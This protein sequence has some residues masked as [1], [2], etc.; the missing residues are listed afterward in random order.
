MR[1]FLVCL[2]A[3]FIAQ[4]LKVIINTIKYFISKHKGQAAEKVT[5]ETLFKL[6]GMPSSHTA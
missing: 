5:Y 6:G 4:V 3:W 2:I 1:I